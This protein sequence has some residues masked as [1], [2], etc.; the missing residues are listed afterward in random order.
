MATRVEDR[1]TARPVSAKSGGMVGL[2][3]LAGSELRLMRREPGILWVI[4]LPILLSVVF[5]LIPGTSTPSPDF[6]GGRFIDFYV[7]V[8]VCFVIAMMALNVVA[9][10]L[11][12]YRERGVLRRLAVTPVR[13]ATLLLAQGLVSF[14]ILVGV[15]AAMVLITG[16]GFHV[17]MPRQVFGFLL[18]LVLAV[19]SMFSIGLLVA[20]LAPTGRAANGIGTVVMFPSVFFAGLWTPGPMMSDTIR[21][22]AEWTP[23]GAGSQAIQEAWA[24]TFPSLFHLAVPLGYTLVVGWVAVKKFRWE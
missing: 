16:L 9:S 22:I 20:A 8:L 15:V 4:A 10:A 11:G 14:A 23:L 18:A 19:A 7:P 21:G 17:P 3:R 13:P 2:G 5:G 6:G 1:V 12:T 24:G